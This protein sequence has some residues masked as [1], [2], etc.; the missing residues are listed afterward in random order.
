M[1]A[2]V[3]DRNVAKRKLLYEVFR[4]SS[5]NVPAS[6][7]RQ[8]FVEQLEEGFG[9]VAGAIWIKSAEGNLVLT[10]QWNLGTVGLQPQSDGWNRH[11][12]LL[13]RSLKAELPRRIGP[14]SRDNPTGGEIL[15]ASTVVA[16]SVNLIVEVFRHA[17]ED[18][19]NTDSDLL[20]LTHLTEIAAGHIRSQELERVS[21]TMSR[22]L[23]H[24][25]FTRNVHDSLAP[26]R[27]ATVLANDGR[28]V[29]D[30]DRLSVFLFDG[31]RVRV[32]SVSGQAVIQRKSN[33][34]L[35]MERVADEVARSGKAL[36]YRGGERSDETEPSRAVAE[37]AA[38]SGARLLFAVPLHD[39]GSKCVLGVLLAEWY[40]DRVSVADVQE[41]V[42]LVASH[43]AIALKN[44]IHHDSIFLRGT[45]H[46]LSRMMRRGMRW[47]SVL[48][49]VCVS[50][51]AVACCVIPGD[52]KVAGTGHLR[53]ARR[54]GLFAP[55]AAIVKEVV[56]EHGVHVRAG[57]PVIIL[58]SPEL[59]AELDHNR[60]QVLQN[61]ERL[62]LREATRGDRRLTPIEQIQLDAE[63]ADLQETK[64]YLQRQTKLLDARADSLV[65]RAPFDGQILTWNPSQ[66]LAGRPVMS[67]NLLMEMADQAG[68]WQLEL[69]IPENQA[70]HLLHHKSRSDKPMQVEYILATE[71]ERRY[72]AIVA[73]IARRTESWH[74]R[75]SVIL[76]AT[77]DP[78]ALPAMRD[79][80]E[81]RCKIHCGQHP[82]GY[83]WFRDVVAFVYSHLL[84]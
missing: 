54:Q 76:T 45:R 5:H 12:K 19:E 46:C 49:A 16:G 4:Q 72:R 79:G 24:E 11:G 62:A 18:P 40:D 82:V 53:A 69:R 55:E 23:L 80:A 42:A 39:V 44:G 74:D 52:M 29:L 48:L 67:G 78:S 63:I 77:P 50:A 28:A 33:A 83:V 66:R 37:F 2:I 73:Q 20:L 64:T 65:V 22:R 30:C 41:A 15:L 35:A 32:D 36:I 3:E 47:R 60:A 56:A 31:S 61:Q 68:S 17:S 10:D 84:F 51:I 9:A 71:P 57:Q 27:V 6:R 70:G 25:E 59:Q 14:E 1:N 21:R 81:V 38:G 13:S 8:V 26:H 58:D 43:G 7:F 75:H 34:I